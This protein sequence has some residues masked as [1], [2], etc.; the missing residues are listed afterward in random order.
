MEY[1]SRDISFF[2]EPLIILFFLFTNFVRGK[3]VFCLLLFSF[4]FSFFATL[5]T[6]LSKGK[7]TFLVPLL[8]TDRSIKMTDRPGER[9]EFEFQSSDPIAILSRLGYDKEGWEK[10]E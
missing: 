6:T 2:K 7:T 9:F 1:I 3:S 8:R 4:F 5:S 10:H